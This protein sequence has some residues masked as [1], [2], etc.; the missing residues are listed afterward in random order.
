MLDKIQS[1]YGLTIMP[2]GRAVD[3]ND[4]QPATP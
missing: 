3:H 4:P 2:F 1:Y